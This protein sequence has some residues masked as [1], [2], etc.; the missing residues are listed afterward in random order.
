MDTVPLPQLLVRHKGGIDICRV[1]ATLM[2]QPNAA[3]SLTPLP[4]HMAGEGIGVYSS[5][6]ALLAVTHPTSVGIYAA[7]NTNGASL[8]PLAVV[9]R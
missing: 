8:E 6:G 2:D 9:E 1:D 4:F 7:S 3:A 5:D